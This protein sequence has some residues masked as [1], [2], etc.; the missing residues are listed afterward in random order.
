MNPFLEAI[1]SVTGPLT[2]LA[3][4]VVVFLYIY[5]RSV[6]E[7]R[8]LEFI[9]ELFRYEL[10]RNKLTRD[11]FYDITKTIIKYAF[12]GFM[13]IFVVSI[14]A[15]LVTL[16][17]PANT[18]AGDSGGAKQAVNVK[19]SWELGLNVAELTFY[20]LLEVVDPLLEDAPSITT[21]VSRNLETLD[22]DA[23]IPEEWNSKSSAVFQST[24]EGSLM[25]NSAHLFY[26]YKY[27]YFLQRDRLSL[28]LF[29]NPSQFAS[30][31]VAME[32]FGIYEKDWLATRDTYVEIE[33]IIALPVEFRNRS[34]GSFQKRFDL[35]AA[36]TSE[37]KAAI[38]RELS[39]DIESYMRDI[40]D[41]LTDQIFESTE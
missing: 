32:L 7:E 35:S 30:E 36:Q 11:H 14:V 23:S 28:I 40:T 8:G 10:F 9:Y 39:D 21:N 20:Q 2:L 19:T 16:F 29:E 6:N 25:R 27:G 31:D 26:W 37:E 5:R 3:F 4:L 17:V 41:Y 12:W 24:L 18:S 15:Y 22:I 38:A 34:N 13:V 1:S 33:D